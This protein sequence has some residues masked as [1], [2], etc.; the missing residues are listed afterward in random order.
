MG[1]LKGVF[2]SEE[3]EAKYTKKWYNR[4]R[5]N[6]EKKKLTITPK[7]SETIVPNENAKTPEMLKV[8]G[9]A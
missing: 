9:E 7:S 8:C 1:Y 3:N 5:E 4:R 2:E 6:Q